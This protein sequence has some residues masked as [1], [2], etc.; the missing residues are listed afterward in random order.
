MGTIRINATLYYPP[1]PWGLNCRVAG[2]NVQVIDKDAP[3]RGDDVIWTGTT[4]GQGRLEGTS[5]EWQDTLSVP[6]WICD[7]HRTVFG[8]RVCVRG[9]WGTQTVPDLTDIRLLFAR[10]RLGN[11]DV[12]VPYPYVGD[13]AP[14]IPLVA[15]PPFEP[16]PNIL[17]VLPPQRA[18]ILVTHLVGPGPDRWKRLYEFMNIAGLAVASQT[19]AAKYSVLLPLTGAQAT[20]G[21]FLQAVQSQSSPA[22]IRTVDVILNLHGAQEEVVFADRQARIADLQNELSQAGR[23]KLRMLYS[24]A[25]Y[26]S[27]H[28]DN[29]LAAGFRVVAGAKGVNANSM[30]EYPVVLSAWGHGAPFGTAIALGEREDTRLP[31][32]EIA[33]AMGFTDVNSD[34]DVLGNPAITISMPNV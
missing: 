13:N 7:E 1:G 12:T 30:T 2:A 18:L 9:H 17:P 31:M 4:D 33:R 15:P 20:R 26:G 22:S 11:W 23:G 25:C 16:P 32:D 27:C 6:E 21:G 19:L 24:T 5:A 8:K 34:K 3:G 28:A 10:I 29:W 14:A